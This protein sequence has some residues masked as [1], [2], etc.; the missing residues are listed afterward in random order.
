MVALEMG[1][2]KVKVA[3]STRPDQKPRIKEIA[4][5]DLAAL[6]A[7]LAKAKVRFGLPDS[8]PVL[9]CYEAGRDGFWLHRWLTNEGIANLV[10]DPGSLKVDRR[11]K[12][13]KTDRIDAVLLLGS[14]YDH[15][16][17]KKGVWS[18]VRPPTLEQEECRQL[19][20]ELETLIGERTEHVNRIKS[21]W[22]PW[23]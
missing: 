15:A 16:S 17:G 13:A 9:C 1:W 2:S 12:R 23:A 3:S 18:V 11:R 5:R 14:L 7:E 4:A 8:A 20:R 6:K 21:L 19:H 10:V 22:R